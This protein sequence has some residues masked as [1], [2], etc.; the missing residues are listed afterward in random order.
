MAVTFP[1]YPHGQAPPGTP[2]RASH[3]LC[4]QRQL[5]DPDSGRCVNCGKETKDTIADTWQRRAAQIARKR[6]R[7]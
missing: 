2:K 7:P 6:A 4:R 5:I 1:R 3:C